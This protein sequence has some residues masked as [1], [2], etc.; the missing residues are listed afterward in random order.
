M[1]SLIKDQKPPLFYGSVCSGIEAASVAWKD[2]GWR[3]AWFSEIESF[4][5]KLL[6]TRYPSVNNIG[7]MLSAPS[8]LRSGEII[9]PDILIGGTP[10]QAFSVSGRREGLSDPRGQLTLAFV[11]IASAI[12]DVRKGADQPESI[13]V[14]ENVTGVLNSADNAFGCFLGALAGESGALQPARGRWPNAGVVSG[15][16]RTV[17]WRVLDAKY[18]GVPQ[19]RKRVFVIASARPDFDPGAALFEFQ[20]VRP[21]SKNYYGAP[22]KSESDTDSGIE[23]EFKT[24]SIDAIPRYTGTLV[25]NYTGTSSQD[26]AMLGGLI[27]ETNPVR[28]RRLTPTEC[29]RLQGFPVGYTDLGGTSPTRR[30]HALGNS[31]A[32]P[33]IKW[34][35]EQI[36]F[37]LAE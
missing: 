31:M 22:K 8:L 16:S 14:W 5:C 1:T 11:D 27:T 36:D 34:L 23:R 4:P 25:A 17:A 13:I 21:R 12:D 33:V 9:A 10:C 19:Q 30:Y 7:D 28:V 20:P 6:N 32:V 26:M 2:F 15:P 3:P 37:H 35:G 29:E 18:F 24:Y